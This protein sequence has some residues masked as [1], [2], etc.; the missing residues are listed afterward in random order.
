LK[1]SLNE[2]TSIELSRRKSRE[3]TATTS[4]SRRSASPTHKTTMNPEEEEA[5]RL[6]KEKWQHAKEAKQAERA[7]KAE[8]K[9]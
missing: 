5:A 4:G 6:R 2:A 8:E 1:G 9:L 7:A 3:D